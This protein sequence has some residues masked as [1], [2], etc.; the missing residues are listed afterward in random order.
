[1]SLSMSCLQVKMQLAVILPTEDNI[2]YQIGVIHSECH[3][4][5]AKSPPSNTSQSRFYSEKC[6]LSKTAAYLEMM[7]SPES[8]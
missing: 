2:E 5:T 8:Y 7:A 6:R 4:N 3:I 1:M